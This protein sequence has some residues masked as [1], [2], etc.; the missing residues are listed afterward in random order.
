MRRRYSL[1]HLTPSGSE[2]PIRQSFRAC[3]NAGMNQKH[4][5]PRQRSS[6]LA[7]TIVVVLMALPLLYGLSIG[8]AAYLLHNGSISEAQAIPFYRPI[9]WMF[10][11]CP[12]LRKPGRWYIALW[13]PPG[14]GTTDYPVF[15]LY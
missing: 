11:A 15:S 12:P 9:G 1:F 14:P 8:P 2:K 7:A 5:K 6:R 4:G 3:Y 10:E 13:L